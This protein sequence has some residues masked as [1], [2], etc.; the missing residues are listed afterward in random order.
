M[1]T[2]IKPFDVQLLIP[3]K[4]R[5][6]RVPRITSTEIYDGTSEDFNPGGL[7]SQILFG[8]VGSQNRDYTFGYIK[9]NTELIHP[10][11]RRWIKQL[12]RYYESIWRGEAFAIWNP[13]TGEFDPADLGDDDADTGYHFFI[14][15]INELKFKRNT[16]ARRNQMI[17]AYEKYRGQLTLVNH[18]VLPAG[19]RDLQIAQNGRTTEDESNDYYRRLLRL[20]NSL[21][22]S[23]LQ[24]AEINNVR[25]NMQMIVDDLYD[26]FL[27][28]LDGKKGFLQSRFGARNLFLGTR[29]V[30]SSM[31]M[32]ADILGDPSAPTVDTILIGL[33]QCL[34]GS[35]PHVVYLMR[36][37]RLYTTSFPSRD[38][39][40][41]LVH[42][43]RLT[44]TNVQ[45]DDIAID[46][47][48][49]IEGNEA[50]IDAF[51]KDSF[52]T[53]PIMINGHYLGLI[54][55]DSEKY[56][57][58]SDITELPNGWDKDKVRPI[59]YIEWLYLISHQ[60]I[61]EKKVEMTRYPVTGDGSS[62]IG[63]VYV[64][65]TTPSIRL[66][67][68]EDGQPTGEF[69]LEYPVLNGSFFQ[70]MSPHGS[71]LPELGADFDGDKMS[72]NFI[73]SKDAIEEINRNAGK[74]ISVIRATGKLAYDIE[75]DIVTRA[76]LGLTAPPRG[77]RSKRGE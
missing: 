7:Y 64:K 50:T 47:W 2:P 3:T 29:N 1:T 67:K 73:H 20:A 17:D 26:Y 53:R 23:P 21:E 72:A 77:Y 62:Y 40:A 71:R 61:N 70:T 75:N 44:R 69:A 35:I 18:L 66:E 76:S 46:R 22:N 9:L 8:Q 16:S 45:L 19:L 11:V 41:Y 25:L 4:E 31:D 5:L 63:D 65:T 6:A 57:I 32:G 68:Y 27:S 49:T 38:G 36:N 24:G 59:T 58:L 51:S 30:I 33:F 15:H 37:D 55:Q 12:K 54:Y 39:D 28:L 42:P 60:A 48:V 10:T 52:K 74:R 14:S 56:Q 13:K 34:K 43:T